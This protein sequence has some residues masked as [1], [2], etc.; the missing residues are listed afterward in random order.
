MEV[1]TG[2]LPSLL[3]KLRELLVGEYNL[4]K[5]VKGGI[6]FLQAELESM[7][8][9]LDKISMTPTDQ[10][11]CQDMIWA[12]S[13]RE[14]S[15]DIEDKID[16]FM[17]H[18]KGNKPDKHH[19]FK[20]FIDR[21]LDL[22]MQ[23]KVRH[24]IA[25]DIR[26]IK[27][28]VKDV[29]ERRDRYSVNN[30][31]VPNKPI[32]VDPRLLMRYENTAWL[33]GI[34]EARDEVLKILMDGNERSMQHDKIVSIV[35]FGGLG[36]TTLA[37]MVYEYLRPKFD[38]SAFISVSRTPDKDKLFKDM[39]Y[40]L[41]KKNSGSIDV[42][43]ELR[44][45]LDK[46]RY[47]IVLDDIWD[48]SVWRIIKCAL[49]DNSLG[50]KIITT[51]RILSVA[52]QADLEIEKD[53][54]IWLWIAE[55]FIQCEEWGKSLFELGESYFRELINRKNFVTTLNDVDYLSP[56][57]MTRRLSIQ[58]GKVDKC[59]KVL[60]ILGLQGCDLSKGFSLRVIGYLFH[61][62]GIKVSNWIGSLT[63]LEELSLVHIENESI[64]TT[65]ELGLLT[66]LRVLNISLSSKWN[67]KLV[68]CLFKLQK[69]QTLYITKL[70][71]AKRNVGGLD[72]W[73]APGHLRRLQTQGGCWFS[74]L[75]SWM[76]P[77][78]LWNISILSIAVMEMQQKDLENL[79]RLPVLRYLDLQVD[80]K[81]ARSHWEVCL[82]SRLDFTFHVR[83]T[84]ETAGTHGSFDLGLEN[85]TSLQNVYIGVLS[86][87]ASK[88]EVKETKASVRHATG[89]HPNH[90]TLEIYGLQDEVVDDVAAITFIGGVMEDPN[91]PYLLAIAGEE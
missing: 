70:S 47:L 43:D 77:S 51:T 33:V 38:C 57:K 59:F 17:V 58:S 81:K 53:R 79:G 30:N 69:I 4:Q 61:L 64:D 74:T 91:P 9:A 19:G 21:S 48:I 3:P 34:E 20:K 75:P 36:K 32:T 85:L 80:H 56:S 90:P 65:E 31:D 60:R 45:F 86:G 71:G 29:S 40:K 1:V 67:D 14:L 42:I 28:R 27:C 22:L 5:E 87:G 12:R 54:L 73:I 37:N 8:V 63:S 35:G 7:K 82:F 89:I 2:A 10:L 6:I 39:L 24:R 41:S 49:P 13:V 23:P 83:E 88:E 15:Y 44:E 66:E 55:G 25:M 72:A 18:C 11:D 52:E 84:T 68:E 76:N 26:D 78:H 50:C 46:K 16:S 62:R